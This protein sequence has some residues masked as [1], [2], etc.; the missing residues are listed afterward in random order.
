M[1]FPVGSVYT[2]VE[3]EMWS[4]TIVVHKL[5]PAKVSHWSKALSVNR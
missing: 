2:L 4:L 1:G 3:S 5:L